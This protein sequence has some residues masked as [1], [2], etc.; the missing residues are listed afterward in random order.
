MATYKVTQKLYQTVIQE[1]W[2]E[3]DTN[4]Q[5]KWDV[6]RS[7]AEDQMDEDEFAEIPEKAPEDPSLWFQ[8][9]KH[10]EVLEYQ[11]SEP[12][13]WVSNRKG[14]TEYAYILEDSEGEVIQSEEP[15][16]F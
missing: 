13:D 15:D 11:N 6:L 12:D 8:L 9:Y 16:L 7:Y 10:Y 14:S 3:F 2:E 4:D 5:E 1:F